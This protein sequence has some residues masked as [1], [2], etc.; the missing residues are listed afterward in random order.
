MPSYLE[1]YI[2]S[3]VKSIGSSSSLSRAKE[4]KEPATSAELES[5]NS[6]VR[7]VAL[8]QEKLASTHIADSKVSKKLSMK[9]LFQPTV[10]V[11]V[12]Q[13]LMRNDLD[14]EFGSPPRK[15]PRLTGNRLS[16]A[17]KSRAM[18]IDISTPSTSRSVSKQRR[19]S[20][21]FTPR[22]SRQNETMCK[23][24]SGV[25]LEDSSKDSVTEIGNSAE[26]ESK[27]VAPRTAPRKVL[28]PDFSSESAKALIAQFEKEK[29]AREAQS[30]VDSPANDKS[31][32]SILE[33][34]TAYVEFRTNHENRSKCVQDELTAIGATISHKLNSTVTH[35]IF[36]DGSLATYNKAK[37]MG[38]FI[39]SAMWI[40][41]CKL[42]KAKV[43]EAL[44]P[45]VSKDRYDSP[46]LFPKLR[47]FK[48]MQPKTDEEIR[49][50]QALKA[51]RSKRKKKATPKAKPDP[52]KETVE[53]TPRPKVR[54]INT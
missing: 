45:S 31:L 37:K 29:L 40:E 44:F 25:K 14:P 48:S 30:D 20:A 7:N 15:S 46:G 32:S 51:T 13:W 28:E 26:A 47:K 2:T 21:M 8:T 24:M 3:P 16:S 54:L 1:A 39:V 50:E 22:T 41:A 43:S 27:P 9:R 5:E 36:K 11:Q 35:M 18:S 17:L 12:E 49:A 10:L 34:V 4:P 53:A 6:F 42:E 38:I 52:Q 19:V 33:G 23:S